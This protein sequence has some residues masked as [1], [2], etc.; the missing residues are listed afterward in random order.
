MPGGAPTRSADGGPGRS[1]GRARTRREG[2]LPDRARLNGVP[3]WML[4]AAVLGLAFILVPPLAMALR[5]DWAHFIPLVTGEAALDALS[6]SLRTA[7]LSTALC[8]LLGVPLAALLSR[9]EFPGKRVLR[10]LVLLPL[11]IPPVVGGLALLYAFGR[12]GLLGPPLRAMGV[13]LSFSTAAVVL[14]QAFVSLPYLVLSMEGALS[15]G[16]A[17]YETAAATLGASPA[18]TWWRVTLPLALPGLLSGAVL[19]FARCLGEFGATL[20]FAG[21]LQGVTRTLPLEIYLARESDPDAAAA[22]ALL[23]VA[24]AILAVALAHGPWAARRRRT[25]AR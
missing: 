24:V 17:R 21:N 20:T 22:L 7:C 15:S 5:V 25:G 1:A 6:L 18:L 8:V 23:L 2:D 3:G 14:A 12:F 10:A 16:D 4:L 9:A 11:V 13:E 19:A